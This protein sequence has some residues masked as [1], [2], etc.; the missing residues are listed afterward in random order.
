LYWFI[1]AVTGIAAE[2]V[3]SVA[4]AP[5]AP[6][7]GPVVVSNPAGEGVV[8]D[9]GIK[10]A[11]RHGDYTKKM[12][13]APHMKVVAST[14]FGVEAHEEFVDVG[15]VAGGGIVAFGNTWG[16]QFVK[17]P[18][19]VILGKGAHSGK[20]SA[21]K[22]KKG[23]DVL[24]YRNPDCVGMMV[25]YAE[26]LKSIVKIAKMDWGVANI[27]SGMV[28]ADGRGLIVAG[29]CH[30][31]F[32]TFSAGCSKVNVLPY[33]APAPDAKKKP[34]D[35]ATL[36]DIYVARFDAATLKPE[37]IWV[38]EKNGDVPAD[39]F[40]DKAGNVYFDAAGMQRISADGKDVKLINPKC[41]SGTAKWLGVDPEDGGVFFGGD[42][43][44][45]T[46][47][48][49]Y[50]QPF[51]YKF[52][53]KGAKVQTLWEPKPSEIGSGPEDGH[54]ESDSSPRS[55]AWA[56]NG[57][58]LVSGWSDGGNSVFPRQALD[59]R[60]PAPD[61]G[62]A[63]Q[64]WGM[65][66]ASSLGHIMRIDPK[67]WETKSHA[68]WAG[69]IP[70]WFSSPKNRGAPNGLSIERMCVLN[71]GSVAIVGGSATGLLQTPNAFWLDSMSGDKYGGYYV[72]VFLP[73]LSNLMFSS[74][75]PGC[76]PV[77]IGATRKGV[78]IASRA[79]RDDGNVK[80]PTQPPIKN[81]I[82]K[83]FGG[84]TDAHIVIL[85]FSER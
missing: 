48:E 30:P 82:Q 45:K 2:P 3:E 43:N 35:P 83:E 6:T 57:D 14:F 26:D 55:M 84:N 7:S 8:T 74:Y 33:R 28:T 56:A 54:L 53:V 39:L 5:V 58:L 32:K 79:K 38:L 67:T 21:S 59:W 78:A 19:A 50:R 22:D 31:G 1:L 70:S 73:N 44:T 20:P 40:A 49:P 52:D 41:S 27:R 60:K 11:G 24:E 16:P 13:S 12:M 66:G 85:E 63:L 37:W 62:M 42:R 51:L 46:G 47:H 34:V 10:S 36:E 18:A 4:A 72:S 81:A 77:A 80:R 71:D 76:G 69:F 61:G 75:M 23:N 15:G 29:Q 64:T 65:K 9:V 25:M 17:T 68:W